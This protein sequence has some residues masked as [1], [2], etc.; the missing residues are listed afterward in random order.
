MSNHSHKKRVLVIGGALG[1]LFAGTLLQQIG[2]EVDIFERSAHDLDSRGG[3]IVL[4]PEV[5]EVFRRAGVDIGAIEL[6]VRSDYRTVFRP[7]GSIQSKHLA[8]QTQTSWSLIYTTLKAAFGEG[9]Y[10]RAKT[11]VSIDQDPEAQTVSARFEDGTRE[12]GA[13]LI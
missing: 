1:G 9:D 12:T 6:G 3:G 5:V 11:L 8:P 13:L 10:H 4:Q 7:D 2:W